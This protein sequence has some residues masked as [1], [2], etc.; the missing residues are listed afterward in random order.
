M[1]FK[2]FLQQ[3]KRG[4]KRT[5]LNMILLSAAVA[6]FVMSVNL[7]QNSVAN[8]QKVEENYS[9]IALM[10]LYGDVDSAGNLADPETDEDV[11]NTS[12]AVKGYDISNIVQADGVTGYDLRSK[13]AA[14]IEGEPAMAS[15]IQPA[16]GY[17]VIRFKLVDNEPIVLPVVW[18][19]DDS[20]G[21]M[22]PLKMQV[23]EN[24]VE[25]ADYGVM[26]RVDGSIFMSNSEKAVYADAVRQLNRS[27]EVDTITL[28]PGVEYVAS[29]RLQPEWENAKHG[30]RMDGLYAFSQRFSFI[31]TDS[32]HAAEDIHVTY[33][34]STKETISYTT[35][36]KIGQPFPLARW[37][38]VQ[39]DPALKSYYEEAMYAAKITGS[40]FNVDLTN[41]FTS[42]AAYHLGGL[43]LYNGRLITEEEY[44]SGA[45][46]CMISRETAKYQEWKIGQ[47]LN[48]KFYDFGPMTNTNS[49]LGGQGP[50][51]HKD[52]EGFFDEVEYEIVGI[53]QENQISGN[54]GIAESTLSA[55]WNIIYVPEKSVN[56]SIPE[57]EQIIHGSRLSIRLENGSIDRFLSDMDELGLTES[58]N[59]QYNPKFSFYDQGYSLIQGGLDSMLSTS[60]LL[61]ILSTALL[62]VTGILLSFFFAQNQ[63]QNVGIFRMLGGTKRHAV[64]GILACAL[65]ITIIGAALGGTVGYLLAKNVGESIVE[66]N[67]AQS[68]QNASYQ[69]FV[70]QTGKE[71]Q[72]LSVQADLPLTIMA[73]GSAILFPVLIVGFVAAYI[74]DEPR[75][76]LPKSGK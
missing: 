75:T 41:D 18:S 23:L 47:K 5:F 52:V 51:W 3:L 44:E 49:E 24:S 10:E 63:K 55:P 15:Q 45:K 39:A 8:L 74:N 57:D 33:S 40:T 42:V 67:Q 50:F 22:I 73:S 31:P 6:F 53:Y 54:S 1:H 26:F 64:S 9:T 76:L 34:S 32:K 7:Y 25:T 60:K 70:L 21:T 56:I 46:V 20:E 72:T 59:G 19:S 36:I 28:Y 14:Y 37:E 27:D 65:I 4:K 61:L 48:M 11:R 35:G 43:S 12:V 58:K 2:I 38:D 13:Y 17:D 71:A 62:I 29:I 16:G 68:Q 69:A 66:E 30:L